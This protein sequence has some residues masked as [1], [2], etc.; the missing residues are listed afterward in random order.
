MGIEAA[1]GG[2]KSCEKH[3]IPAGIGLR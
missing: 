3:A 1:A 2:S